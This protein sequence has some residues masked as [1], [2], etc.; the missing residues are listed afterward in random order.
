MSMLPMTH[1]DRIV[2]NTTPVP[3][4]SLSKKLIQAF[5]TR[6]VRIRQA[7]QQRQLMDQLSEHQLRDVGLERVHDGHDWH[8]H[9]IE[10][11]K[12]GRHR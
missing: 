8:L 10:Q 4:S 6:L 7:R 3:G 9:P 1:L 12:T 11:P 2:I 5:T